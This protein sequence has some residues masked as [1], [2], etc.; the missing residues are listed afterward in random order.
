M[1][2]AG[3]AGFRPRGVGA[4]RGGVCTLGIRK[5]GR[6]NA[7]ATERSL[8]QTSCTAGAAKRTFRTPGPIRDSPKR[9]IASEIND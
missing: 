6:L 3:Q 8:R 2:C 1:V 9:V 5:D 7:G 4:T